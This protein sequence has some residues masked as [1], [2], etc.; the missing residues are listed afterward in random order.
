MTIGIREIVIN[1]D[2]FMTQKKR[3]NQFCDYFIEN[4]MD[5][6]FS[7]D[8]GISIW[9]V[10][11]ELLVKMKKAGFYSLRFPI[12][13]GCKNTLE[14][15]K[16]PV[17]L[18]RAK[19]MIEEANRLGFWTSSNIIVGFPHETREE[20]MESIQY[21]YNSTLD[22]TSFLI[23]KPNAG[24]D[25]YDDFKKE[26]LLEKVVIRGS[27]FYR[28]DY[29]TLTMTSQELGYMVD[30]ASSGWFIHKF[31]FYAKPINF[32]KYFLPKIK[33]WEDFM[34]FLKMCRVVFSKKIRPILLSKLWIKWWHH[35]A[36][37]I[38]VWFNIEDTK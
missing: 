3:V 25:M 38:A 24:S 6:S 15:I 7:V 37:Y 28:S 33:S 36:I 10:D 5:I 14:Y 20:I 21:V 27:D 32:Y 1:D 11:K 13:S 29:D 35:K 31:W 23:A 17:N 9:L 34:Y 4:K 16:K 8:A 22:F 19:S 12:E 30:K 2:Q 18:D 26:G